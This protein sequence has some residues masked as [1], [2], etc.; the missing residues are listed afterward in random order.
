MAQAG[1]SLTFEQEVALVVI[2]G[3]VIGLFI[4][5][6]SY[7]LNRQLERFRGQQELRRAEDRLRDET[8][9]KHLEAQIGDL[10]G[11]LFGIQQTAL[12]MSQ[13]F[14]KRLTLTQDTDEQGKIKRHY[15]GRYLLP[16]N[17]AMVELI[18]SKSHLLD[19]EEMP[20]SF[21][22]FLEHQAQVESLYTLGIEE[23][24]HSDNLTPVSYP[25][26]FGQD[27]RRTLDELRKR[28]RERQRK[29]FS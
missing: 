29:L 2:Q 8:G 28:Y 7:F 17:Q 11:P 13:V 15:L 5:V 19:S 3:L 25:E 24:V 21:S 9:L 18:R 20:K 14:R 26:D 12:A 1:A 6:A 4:L 16:L 27:V 23:H 10:Y 22:K